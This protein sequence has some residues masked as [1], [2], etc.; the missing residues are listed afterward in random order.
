MIRA[1]VVLSLLLLAPP[2]PPPFTARWQSQTS[3]RVSWTQPPGVLLT[4]L[5]RGAILIRCWSALPAGPAML[6]LGATGPLDGNFRPQAHDVFVLQQDG[7]T[8]RAALLGVRYL[9]VV[10]R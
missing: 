10:R 8:D 2:A 3:A 1:I 9:A 5:S 4:C 7:A 6:V